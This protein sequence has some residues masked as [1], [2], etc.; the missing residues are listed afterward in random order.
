MK[1]FAVYTGMRLG[2]LVA[3]FALV[4]GLWDLLNGDDPVPLLPTLLLAFLISG[5]ASYF[6]LNHQREAFARRV[7]ERAE[8]ASAALEERR[9]RE[10]REQ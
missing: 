4:F 3:S 8:R 10:D 7:Q 9:A 6:L 1:E 5:V 2:L